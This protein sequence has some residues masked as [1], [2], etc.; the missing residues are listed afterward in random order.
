MLWRVSFWPRGCR[1]FIGWI[2]RGF[3]SRILRLRPRTRVFL[4]GDDDQVIVGFISVVGLESFIHHLYI[5][6]GYQRMGVGRMLLESL[7][8]WLPQPYHLKC[9]TANRPAREF[10]QGL[11]WTEGGW[12]SDDLGDYVLMKYSDP[13]C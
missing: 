13:R 5:D 8:A 7:R 2:R 9:L 11:G 3:T 6:R 1:P 10:Y 12:G 4:A